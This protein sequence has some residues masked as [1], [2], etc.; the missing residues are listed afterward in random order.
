MSLL[1]NKH[2]LV[3]G[4][5]G[6]FGNK[7]AVELTKHG[8]A[9]VTIFSRDEKKQHTMQGKYPDFE[10]V[11]G[12]IRNYDSLHSAMKGVDVV[13]QAAALKQVPSCENYPLEALATNCLG[14]ANVLKAAEARE[15]EH[16]VSLSTDK[17]V[18]PVNAMGI[19]K[20]LAEKIVVASKSGMRC[21]VVRYGNITGSRGSVL[22]V[23]RSQIE[24]G[25][26]ITI[27]DPKMTRFL[28]NLKDSV[29][30]VLHALQGGNRIYV[31]E[32]P[33]LSMLD[34]AEAYLNYKGIELD[35]QKNVKIIG[36]RPGEKIHELLIGED[37]LYRTLPREGF[38]EIHPPQ[39]I[40]SY[41]NNPNNLKQPLSSATAHRPVDIN[42]MF[43]EAEKDMEAEL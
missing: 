5:T 39:H 43:V 12:D 34:F 32:A 10:Y 13:F 24:R 20:A 33:A 38:I 21:A 4:G 19:S 15:V 35:A 14:V 30:L 29:A 40:C 18:N 22:P 8:V 1:K 11:I 36:R 28:M 25:D 31:L 16:V 41:L 7:M 6:S 9:K 37:E 26:P 27:T 23:W 42:A 17:S 3:T 2:L